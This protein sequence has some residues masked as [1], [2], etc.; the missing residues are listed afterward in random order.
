MEAKKNEL[1]TRIAT[2]KTKL[3]DETDEKKKKKLGNML[4]F[5]E[6]DL[7]KTVANMTAAKT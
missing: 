5:F 6:K 7:E 2:Y 4:A 3:A 1:T